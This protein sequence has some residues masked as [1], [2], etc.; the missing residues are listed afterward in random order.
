VAKYAEQ[1]WSGT[2]DPNG[3]LTV[4]LVP[5]AA[6]DATLIVAGQAQGNPIWSLLKNGAFLMPGTGPQVGLGPI[7]VKAKETLTI[8][9]TGGL[10]A[11]QVNGTIWGNQSEAA[12]GSDLPPL[13]PQAVGS[14]Q[15]FQQS[16]LLR[17]AYSLAANMVDS[18][19]VNITPGMQVITLYLTAINVLSHVNTCTL[20]LTG[21]STGF[22]Y[23]TGNI[24]IQTLAGGSLVERVLVD[25]AMDSQFTV[26]ISTGAGNLDPIT[27]YVLGGPNPVDQVTAN[28]QDSLGFNINTTPGRDNVNDLEVTMSNAFAAPWQAPNLAPVL[29]NA[30]IGIGADLA[31]IAAV[32]GKAV[33]LFGCAIGMDVAGQGLS[34]QDTASTVYHSFEGIT[35]TPNPFLGF[36]TPLPLGLG[37]KL[38][39]GGAAALTVRG[40]LVASQA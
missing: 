16:T 1:A 28:I 6:Y 20:T 32:G 17:P 19:N 18:R 37:A 22:Q 26:K 33:Y 3:N 7:Y 31:L 36:G 2:F 27:V 10:P 15:S 9:L 12:N 11:T 8:K 34:I 14:Q 5:F 21:V 40:S 29:I 23:F 30:T 35:T 4:N 25:F 38:H 24:T 13:T 39:N